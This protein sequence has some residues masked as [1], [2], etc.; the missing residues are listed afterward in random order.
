[1][2]YWLR[3]KYFS[4]YSSPLGRIVLASDGDKITGLWFDGQKH[5]RLGLNK[6]AIE[7]DLPIFNQTKIWLDQYFSGQDPGFTPE[8]EISGT[9]FQKRV[10]RLLLGIPFGKT[11]TYGQL[12]KQVASELDKQKMSARAVGSAVGYN[13]IS[14]IIPCHRVISSG[15]KLGG[16]SS[17]IERKLELLKLEGGIKKNPDH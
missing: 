4:F 8:I 1:M 16:Y 10:A 15:G 2:L 14:L 12:A 7:K 17:G 13:K 3:M 6:V 5:D 9:D 11:I